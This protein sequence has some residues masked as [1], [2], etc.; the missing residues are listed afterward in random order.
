MLFHESEYDQLIF[1]PS[2]WFTT[3]TF[4]CTLI[5]SLALRAFLDTYSTYSAPEYKV[6]CIGTDYEY[7]F[8]T[9]KY[10]INTC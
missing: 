9:V 8:M 2:I 7:H 1:Q 4:W 3:Y 5:K 10:Q 6:Y